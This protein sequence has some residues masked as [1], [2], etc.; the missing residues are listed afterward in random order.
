MSG[1]NIKKKYL[2]IIYSNQNVEK[3]ATQTQVYRDERLS[4]MDY[5]YVV[6]IAILK[7]RIF[8]GRCHF[9]SSVFASTGE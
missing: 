3:N 1:Q 7:L 4:K 2:I 5:M 6:N 8:S 9:R